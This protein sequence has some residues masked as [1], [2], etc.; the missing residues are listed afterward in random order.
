M[1]VKTGNNYISRA[2]TD[3]VEIPTTNSE[4]FDHD[5][6]SKKCSEVT[7][8]AQNTTAAPKTS[9]PYSVVGRCQ[10]RPE[11]WSKHP[12]CRWN[13]DTISVKIPEI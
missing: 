12:I 1:A 2:T 3:I 8:T 9:M 5:Y 6:S 13:F 7:A 4:I 10:C 11:T